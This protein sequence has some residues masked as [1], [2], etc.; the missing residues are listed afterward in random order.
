MTS[1]TP[2]DWC[3]LVVLFL[4]VL[5]GLWRGLVQ[6]MMSILGWIAAF[7]LAPMYAST[8]ARALLPTAWNEVWR[9]AGGFA[10]VFIGVL[11]AT[12]LAAWLITRLIGRV[13]LGPIDR[14]LGSVFGVLRALLI[15]FALVFVV[16]LLGL[17]QRDW[18]RQSHAG[19]WLSAGLPALKLLAPPALAKHL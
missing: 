9:F 12:S 6:E 2:L 3:L 17:D 7:I 10:I 16:R 4:S 13:G 19:P 11:V 15:G 8:A 18:W 1:L 14:L 5:L